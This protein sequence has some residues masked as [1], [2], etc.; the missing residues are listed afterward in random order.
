MIALTLF[1]IQ[2][3]KA[4]PGRDSSKVTDIWVIF[5]TH[6]D[7]GFTDLCGNVFKRYR[8]DMIGNALGLIENNEKQPREKRFPWS[9][10]GNALVATFTR[11]VG[12]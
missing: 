10:A 6:S 11:A 7:L 3:A 12:Y 1:V 8:E 9:V 2:G 5:R 4:Q